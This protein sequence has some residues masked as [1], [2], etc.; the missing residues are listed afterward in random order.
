VAKVFYTCNAPVQTIL[1]PVAG[2]CSILHPGLANTGTR[3]PNYSIS[4]CPE[5][6]ILSE[7]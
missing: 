5:A 6:I 3:H 7:K 1:D 2:L 4:Y